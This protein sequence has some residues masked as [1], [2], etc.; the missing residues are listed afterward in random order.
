MTGQ[1]HP[2]PMSSKRRDDAPRLRIVAKGENPVVPEELRVTPPSGLR[3]RDAKFREIYATWFGDVVKWIYA[4]GVPASE[5]EDV[6]QEIFV[7]VRRH[8]GRFD[9]GNLAGWLYRITQLTVRDH[10]RRA[11]FRNLVLRRDD[12]DLDQVPQVDAA[13]PALDY[14]EA[15]NRRWLQR[16]VAKMSEKLRTTFVLFE[17]EGYSGEEIARIQDVPLGTVWRRLHHARKE[18]WKLVNEQRRGE[19]KSR[20]EEER[21]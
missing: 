9:G 14:E 6:A 12:V 8:L 16:L 3:D 20:D 19:E 18:F 15:E 1:M 4:F 21:R 7:V 5:T 13:G 17:I 11:W 2:M 10:R